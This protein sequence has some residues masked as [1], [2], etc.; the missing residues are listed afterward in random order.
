VTAAELQERHP[1][2][3]CETP[4]CGRIVEAR[5]TELGLQQSDGWKPAAR[6]SC[7][8]GRTRVEPLKVTE[9]CPA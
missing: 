3:K 8:C 6:Y 4:N 5:L 1:P 7:E 2:R 9:S